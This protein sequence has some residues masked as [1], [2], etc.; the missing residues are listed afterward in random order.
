[1]PASPNLS[2]RA[3]LAMYNRAIAPEEKV[4]FARACEAAGT[5]GNLPQKWK[6]RILASEQEVIDAGLMLKYP[7]NDD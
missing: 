7:Q 2:H 4:E 1:M 3:A 6:D 5:F